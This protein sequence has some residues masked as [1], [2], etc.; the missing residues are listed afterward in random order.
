MK[1]IKGTDIKV[2]LEC[3]DHINTVEGEQSVKDYHLNNT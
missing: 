2:W 1:N 3:L